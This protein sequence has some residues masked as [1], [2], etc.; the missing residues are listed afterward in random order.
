MLTGPRNSI[1]DVPGIRVGHAQNAEAA[2]GC[3][4]ILVE[5]GTS[6]GVDVRGGSPGTRETDCL[7]PTAA[8]TSPNAFLLTGGSAF[9]LD[10]ATGVHRYLEERG[11]GFDVMVARV[12]IVSSAVIFDLTV[13]SAAVRPDAEMGMQAC[14]N[15][16]L[17]VRQGNVGAGTGATAGWA[18]G[19]SR[20]MKVGLGTASCRSD[21]LIVGAIVA[22]NCW[23][24]IIIPA[25]GE[26]IAGSLNE[27]GDGFV[28]SQERLLAR[29]QGINPFTTHSTIGVVAT[30]AR[31]D[32]GLAG[33]VA[34]VAHDGYARTIVPVH[35]LG[36]GDIIFCVCIGTVEANVSVVGEMA[37]AAMSEAIL[38]AARHAE[39]AYGYPCS[40]EV[41]ARM[42]ARKS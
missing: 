21:D 36:E 19:M 40:R 15:A 23:G 22:A 11:I 29:P 25:T 10:A 9:G 4:V 39:S 35:T 6:C 3:T 12:P 42:K 8:M 24:D 1:T 38:N 32:K 34:M 37:A 16:G 31:L 41:A 5:G 20:R 26:V 33:R 13:A 7:A 30:N 27:A 2:K 14:R 17:D 18:A 28:G